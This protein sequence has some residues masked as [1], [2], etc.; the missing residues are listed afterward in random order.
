MLNIF[1][2]KS[3]EVTDIKSLDKKGDFIAETRHFP[4]ANNE[5]NNSVYTYNKN[6]IKLLPVADNIIINLIRSYFNMYSSFL[7]RKNKTRRARAWK[8]VL[9]S[10]K[11]WIAKP[12]LKHT[13]DKVIINLY[14]YNRQKKIILMNIKKLLSYKLFTYIKSSI[15]FNNTKFVEEIRKNSKELLTVLDLKGKLLKNLEKNYRKALIKRALKKE[16]FIMHYM[17]SLFFNKFK[18]TSLY[19]EPL[20]ILLSKVYSKKVI[21]NIVKLK[22]Y[23]LNS[24]ILTQILTAKTKNRKNK[25]LKVLKSSILNIKTPVFRKKLIVRESTKL[26]S[27]QNTLLKNIENTNDTLNDVINNNYN[28]FSTLNVLNSIKNK[29]VS[30]IRLEASGRLSKRIVAARSVSKVKY[31]GTL[32]N[33]DS[34]YRGL[35]SVMLRGN[36]K[37]N[38]QTTFLKSKTRIGS[39]GVKGWISS[40]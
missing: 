3:N 5:W 11:F 20:K 28:N 14:V 36:T 30:G 15:K 7:E 37:S 39:F 12:E 9:S 10:K 31:V 4:P 8:R 32:K 23:F 21:F 35:S 1:K 19:I 16:L 13:N 18:F 34:S 24:D 29:T 38:T 17:E 40:V 26:S 33:I 2:K 22:T 25:I 6:S 27:V